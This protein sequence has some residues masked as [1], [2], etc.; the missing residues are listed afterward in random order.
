MSKTFIIL[1]TISQFSNFTQFVSFFSIF[2]G[3]LSFEALTIQSLQIP[4]TLPRPASFRTLT[5]HGRLPMV[6]IA[7]LGLTPRIF[8][9]VVIFQD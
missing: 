5:H 3:G 8:V 4:V 1:F 6:T 2:M 9:N 7:A